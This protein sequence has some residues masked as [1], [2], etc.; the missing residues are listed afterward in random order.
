MDFFRGR[1]WAYVDGAYD[2]VDVRDVAQG[3]VAAADRGRSG[4]GYV[5]SG[6]A[7][8]VVDLLQE[9]A[10]LSGIPAPRLRFPLG[11][12]RA[13]GLVAPAYYRLRRQRPLFTT[14]SVDVINSNYCMDKSK[15]ERELGFSARP[16]TETFSDTIRWFRRE[17]ML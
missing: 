9:L 14:Y 16:L 15:A 11:V 13:V 8:T 10:R 12:A 5:L 2:F 4:E 6:H 3:I 17:G 7:M 1:L